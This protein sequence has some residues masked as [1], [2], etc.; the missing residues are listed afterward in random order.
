LLG[1]GPYHFVSISVPDVSSDARTLNL[2]L[3]N[4]GQFGACVLAS[5]LPGASS[6][7]LQVFSANGV[8][9]WKDAARTYDLERLSSVEHIEPG[10]QLNVS[11]TL[12]APLREGDCVLL[13]A[14][15]EPCRFV[16]DDRVDPTLGV[17]AARMGTAHGFWRFSRGALTPIAE[18]QHGCAEAPAH[19][20]PR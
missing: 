5:T 7:P 12:R 1:S 16:E 19:P 9:R 17:S 15:Y 2:R 18:G 4:D 14:I 3:V 13:D 6:D 10:A 11:T 8:R 20:L